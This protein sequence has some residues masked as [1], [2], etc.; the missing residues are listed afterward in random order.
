MRRY[1][2]KFVVTG[3]GRS[4]TGYASAL[5]T[6]AG[7][8]VG[9]ERY[10]KGCPG[11]GEIAGRRTD[12]LWQVRQP[13]G[14]VRE[15]VRRRLVSLDGDASWLA[16]PRLHRFDGV[17]M[18][19]LRHP[20]SFVNSWVALGFFT[21]PDRH[22]LSA[23]AL[24]FFELSGDPVEDALR[25]WLRWNRWA[26]EFAHAV[27]GLESWSP[28]LL[29]RLLELIGVPDANQR[30]EQA[31]ASVGTDVNSASRRGY[32]PLEL[33]WTDIP[34]SSVKDEAAV[35]AE[36]WGYDVHDLSQSPVVR[37]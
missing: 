27:F 20:V 10:F 37:L 31:F 29:K 11:F 36:R 18:L 26:E 28:E 5:F 33:R 22:P 21:E 23:F 4:G 7:L 17:V 30:A 9:H 13:I 35:V 19:Q 2:L 32:R 15:E 8:K 3:T 34:E 25:W 14:R 6:A 16:V 1:P 24:R 12:V